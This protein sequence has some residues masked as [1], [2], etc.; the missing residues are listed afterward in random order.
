[1]TTGKLAP[2][3]ETGL[4]RHPRR[5]VAAIVRC[6]RLDP[7]YWPQAEA[8]GLTVGRR[9]RLIRA[10]AVEGPAAA[11]LELAAAPWVLG[12]EPDQPVHTTALEGQP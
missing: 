5:I 12:I 6:D 3:F 7:A 11:L 10:I 2:D 4:R 8:L 1:M 9:L